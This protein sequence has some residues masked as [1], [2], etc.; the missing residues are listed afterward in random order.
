M[1]SKHF[2]P[3]K[4]KCWKKPKSKTLKAKSRVKDKFSGK[5]VSKNVLLEIKLLKYKTFLMLE[6]TWWNEVSQHVYLKMYK[7]PLK[8]KL[9]I[10]F[11]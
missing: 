1:P 4:T 5:L 8:K 6:R 10:I 2:L 7:T 11:R 3:A 9:C